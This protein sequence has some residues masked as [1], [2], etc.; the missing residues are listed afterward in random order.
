MKEFMFLFVPLFA[1]LIL[2]VAGF[3]FIH[4]RG[5]MEV[6]K[7]RERAILSHEDELTRRMFTDITADLKIIA[8]APALA[9]FLADRAP[10]TTERLSRIFRALAANRKIYDQV[11]YIDKN[12]MELVRV[13]FNGTTPLRVATDKL[14][15]K[16]R[17]YYFHDTIGLAPGQVFISPMDLNI[18][19]GQIEQPLKPTIRFGTPIFDK[20]GVKQGAIILN[21]MARKLLKRLHDFPFT[22]KADAG[23]PDFLS[24][25]LTETIGVPL[26]LNR[27][28]YFLLSDKPADEW[29]FMLG[30]K[31][32][33]ASRFPDEWQRIRKRKKGQF[34]SRNGLF[35]FITFSPLPGGTISSTGSPYPYT[36]S[37]AALPSE[38]VIWKQVSYI[39]AEKIAGVSSD[40]REHLSLLFI[41]LSIGLVPICIRMASA[42]VYRRKSEQKQRLLIRELRES[43]DNVKTLSG[44]IPICASCKKIRDDEGYWEQVESYI[45]HHSGARFSHGICPDC[46]K[47]IYP[48]LY[49]DRE[50]R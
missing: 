29:G 32:T 47:K 10:K 18:E 4:A 8:A 15:D 24:P 6:L 5:D 13:N 7:A 37:R 3:Y 27:D 21:Y 19:H 9:D 1:L 49:S 17:R 40:V 38:E 43:L 16:S 20:N 12:G 25:R 41:L 46:A 23:K 45:S 39:D 14:Q 48:E 42:R 50:P 34:R 2:I 28:G 35:T 26:L 33:F 30:N 44:F 36:S 22:I 11:R 31:K